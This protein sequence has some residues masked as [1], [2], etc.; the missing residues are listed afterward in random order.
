MSLPDM[1][2][3][4]A[5]IGLS[6]RFPGS[7]DA[8]AYYR[9]LIGGNAL[10]APP[11]RERW[12]WCSEDRVAV[13]SMGVLDDVF[14]FDNALF[15]L[16]PREAETID[17][18]QRLMLE[19]VWLAIEH[20]GYRPEA[21]RGSDTGVFVAMYN[22]DFQFYARSGDWDEISRMYLAMGGAHSLVPN[23]VSYAFDLHGPSEVVDTACSS[24]LVAVHRAVEAI[25]QGECDQA[26][27]GGVSLLLEPG[28][29]VMLQDLGLL[30]ENGD[31]APFDER[32]GG[33]VL[34]EG[35]AAILIKPLAR[36]IA[37][38]DTVHAV[39]RATGVNH[40]GARSGGLTRPSAAAQA[41]LISNTYSRHGIDPA[42]IGYVEAHGNG[43]GGD[44][45]ELLAFQHV[46]PA[47]IAIGSVKGNIGFLEAAGGLSQIVK[48]VLSMRHE[49][50]PA[51]RSHRQMI[52]NDELDPASCRVLT[53]NTPLDALRA[54]EDQSF[55]AGVHAYGLGGCNAHVVLAEALPTADIPEPTD[56]LPL[57]FSGESHV[58]L[59]ARVER[60][61][62]WYGGE[63]YASLRDIAYTLATCG[64]H[65][66]HR[67]VVFA[68]TREE[69]IARLSEWMQDSEPDQHILSFTDDHALLREA[70][71]WC[72][73]EKRDWSR[74][75][76]G[77]RVAMP[78]TTW[79]RRHFPL[80]PL[81]V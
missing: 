74:L 68:S 77:S 7:R 13:R 17:P 49:V 28:R 19:E 81:R 26:I 57:L 45:S 23:R 38:H 58:D 27:V 2:D 15:Q 16:S 80:P 35:A 6:C 69:A 20:A 46:F 22:Q 29:L 73:G 5:I 3:A 34:G 21:F 53:V 79:R 59:R 14:D 71:A 44:V 32:S 30:A 25:R 9:S 41:E 12:N 24:A 66:A 60:F 10:Y 51:T 50:I 18:H 61:I 75:L 43:G 65:E 70:R 47:G 78:L 31:C 36:A 67:V 76:D 4:M 54:P 39:V 62:S 56:P 48:L 55:M 64:F 33:Q 52:Q 72:A 11:P 63:P 1:T 42:A 40:Q 8:E 37:D